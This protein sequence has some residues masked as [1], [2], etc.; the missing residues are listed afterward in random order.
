MPIPKKGF[1]NIEA[2]N[3]E[4]HI[5]TL[6]YNNMTATC[7]HYVTQAQVTAHLKSPED[8][9]RLIEH[10]KQILPSFKSE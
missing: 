10:L 8:V 2:Y 5:G 7:S 4:K 1:I 6:T 3:K 9:V